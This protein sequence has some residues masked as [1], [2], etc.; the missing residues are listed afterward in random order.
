[1]HT[2]SF[3]NEVNALRLLLVLVMFGGALGFGLLDAQA[4]QAKDLEVQAL[5]P[6]CFFYR[7]DKHGILALR[8]C[9]LFI[10]TFP[11]SF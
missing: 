7:Y 10:F 2:I 6:P 4:W 3:V 11:F 5:F 8:D 9:T 1:M